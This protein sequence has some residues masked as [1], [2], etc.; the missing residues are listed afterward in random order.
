MGKPEENKGK[1]TMLLPKLSQLLASKSPALKN[2]LIVGFGLTMMSHSSLFASDLETLR[3]QPDSFN[4]N[5]TYPVYIAQ[6]TQINSPLA[7]GIYLYGQ[8]QKAEEIGKEYLVF[9]VQKGQ[10]IG[11]I[12]FPDS[13]FNCFY[14]N[15]SP[16]QMNISIVDAY[17]PKNIYPY[18]I[19]LSNS[20]TIAEGNGKLTHAVGLEGYYRLKE[21]SQNDQRILN[22]CL[23][24]YQFNQ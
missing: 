1:N 20:S 5:Q 18:P 10:T 19:A 17:N 13:E 7:D 22:T 2:G 15:L 11:A 14:G 4:I 23:N 21:I 16:Q 3:K 24:D 8:S 6:N 12:Y 9:K